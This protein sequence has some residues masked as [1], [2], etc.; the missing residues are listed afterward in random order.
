MA[1]GI[2]VAA[3]TAFRVVVSNR[4]T[5]VD[6]AAGRGKKADAQAVAGARRDATA[7]LLSDD[8]SNKRLG[9]IAVTLDAPPSFDSSTTFVDDGDALGS[10]QQRLRPLSVA[11]DRLVSSSLTRT[12]RRR[13]W[14]L[15]Y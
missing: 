1:A 10:W 6:E 12:G 3:E 13:T 7:R 8:T 11:L 4:E 2:L 5:G 14:L 15:G 9:P